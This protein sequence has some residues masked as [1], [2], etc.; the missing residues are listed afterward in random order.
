MI[1]RVTVSL[2]DDLVDGLDLVAN[3]FEVSR[4]GLLAAL[5]AQMMPPIVEIAT[6]MPDPSQGVTESDVKRFRGASAEIISR[7]IAALLTGG[8]DD[9]FSK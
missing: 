3:R 8:Q 6:I 4:S 5:L 9:L 2:P 7:Q 1:M